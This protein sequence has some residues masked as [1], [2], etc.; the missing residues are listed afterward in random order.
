M[1]GGSKRFLEFDRKLIKQIENEN[2]P[3][4]IVITKVDRLDEDELNGLKSEIR[5][6]FPNINVFSYS[7]D[8]QFAK[9]LEEVGLKDRYIEK[10]KMIDWAIQTLP[11]SLK[12]G[13]LPALKLS[14]TSRRNY[15]LKTEVPKYSGLA[16]VAVMGMSVV[17]V[18]FSDSVPLMALQV[19]MAMSVI[20]DY[21]IHDD[22]AGIVS[23]LVGTSGVSY[24]GKTLASQLTAAIPLIGN[25]V[26]ATVNVSVAA[27][28][29]ATLG[30]AITLVCEQY[31]KACIDKNGAENL[32]FADFFTAERLKQALSYI[33]NNKSEFNIDDIVKSVITK[34]RSSQ[35]S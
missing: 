15:I 33:E 25:F 12:K 2:I 32:A 24:L 31:L 22:I 20:N 3:V 6:S 5:G 17:N 10:D 30:A 4:M 21:S 16:A 27:I 26:K 29:T 11:Y 23:E 9:D 28:V 19:K 35:V 8:K 7:T 14:L 18:P 1:N 13:L 34:A